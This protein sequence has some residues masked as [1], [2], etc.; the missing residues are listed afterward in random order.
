MTEDPTWAEFFRSL[1]ETL[2]ALAIVALFFGPV[3]R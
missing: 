3:M 1:L 2:L